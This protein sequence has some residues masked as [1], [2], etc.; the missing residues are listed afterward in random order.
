MSGGAVKI[1]VGS[2]SHIWCVTEFSQIFRWNGSDWDWILGVGSDVGVGSD[3]S[4]WV[5][6]TIA[7]T[8]GN[9]IFLWNGAD[10]VKQPGGAVAISVGSADHIWDV[11][12]VGEIFRWNSSGSD[13]P[14]WLTVN[15]LSG[16]LNPGSQQ[17]IIV[18][19]DAAGLTPDMY[20]SDIF[21]SSNDSDEPIVTV[22]IT[23]EVLPS[24]VVN[25]SPMNAPIEYALQQN[26]PNP[27]NPVTTI[28]Y[29]LPKNC[30][31]TLKI[32]NTLGHEVVTLVDEQKKAGYYSV[33][34]KAKDIT[35][36]FYFYYIK[37]DEFTKTGKM[38]V[39]K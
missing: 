38:I 32:F 27:F 34:W 29:Q 33:Q 17:D 4:V 3:G 7:T 18:T 25:N 19:F 36:G 9:E 13:L 26:Y 23:L 11:N 10:W 39:L 21:V 8:G 6:S 16:T 20:Y 30:H 2:Q 31:V 37:A 22:P 5:V 14:A 35:S 12:D 28:K 1:G 24:T 15:P